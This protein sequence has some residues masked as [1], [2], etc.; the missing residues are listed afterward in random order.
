[1]TDT[2]DAIIDKMH[3]LFP[4]MREEIEQTRA[5]AAARKAEREELAKRCHPNGEW[6]PHHDCPACQKLI[7]S[8]YFM[9]NLKE[10]ISWEEANG[11]LHS[12]AAILDE[13][14]REKFYGALEY[15]RT[16]YD[17]PKK[18]V[19][20]VIANLFVVLMEEVKKCADKNQ[21]S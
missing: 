16:H 5:K 3:E 6:P 8:K 17:E 19:E 1:M 21:S 20:T 13:Q 11:V 18:I 4:D 7:V 15:A 9:Y 14:S 2:F 12:F 10:N